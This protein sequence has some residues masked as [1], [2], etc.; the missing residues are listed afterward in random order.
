MNIIYSQTA[1]Q[2]CVIH[3]IR[4]S[5]M[6][7]ASKHHKAF[8]SDLKLVYKAASRDAAIDALDELE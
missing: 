6:Y 7:V 3:Q 4:H 1:A 2:L 5:I 8:M